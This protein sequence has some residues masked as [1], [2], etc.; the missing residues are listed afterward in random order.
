MK[1]PWKVWVYLISIKPKRGTPG[2]G[3][4]DYLL[5]GISNLCILI[6]MIFILFTWLCL[7]IRQPSLTIAK[8]LL[9]TILSYKTHNKL[10]VIIACIYQFID[11]T[12]I[13]VSCDD[14][15]KIWISSFHFTQAG[16]FSM[17]GRWI[18]SSLSTT[19]ANF[20]PSMDKKWYA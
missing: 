5:H 16:Y 4:G 3:P 12:I 20:N 7:F 15:K 19:W 6:H 2:I 11:S 13:H 8:L 14:T 1:W 10:K 18:Q 9:L 17:L